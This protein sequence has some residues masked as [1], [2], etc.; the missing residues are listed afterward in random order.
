MALMQLAAL[1]L[2]RG[3]VLQARE[4]T[5]DCVAAAQEAGVRRLFPAALQFFVHVELHEHRYPHVVRIA[6]AETTW[7]EAMAV[8]FARYSAESADW[9]TCAV[10][11]PE[12]DQ[13]ITRLKALPADVFNGLVER[14]RELVR[15]YYGLQD[16]SPR[17][18]N[19]LAE[20]YGVSPARVGE[21]I[22]LAVARLLGPA[23]LPAAIDTCV[24][25]AARLVRRGRRPRA[26]CGKACD[27]GRRRR[28]AVERHARGPWSKGKSN[29]E[30]PI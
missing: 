4:H 9:R 2:A 17:R 29:P 26:P 11:A 14:D 1:A 24:I 6:A 22:R 15:L 16:G 20:R 5:R 10:G 8:G 27:A 18:Q 3:D 12:Y 21:L 30:R 23:T 28:Q 19:E 7:R 13:I 25:C